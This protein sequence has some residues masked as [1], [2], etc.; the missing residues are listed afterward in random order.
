[1]SVSKEGQMD[2][3]DEVCR[4]KARNDSEA[5]DWYTD[6]INKINDLEIQLCGKI[7]FSAIDMN[8]NKE[9]LTKFDDYQKDFYRTL[10][11]QLNAMYVTTNSINSVKGH[12]DISGKIGDVLDFVAPHVL[13]VGLLLG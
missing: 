7:D 1:M 8:L 13:L 11:L 5:V 6:S 9:I 10:V 12:T 2:E 3:C 4:N